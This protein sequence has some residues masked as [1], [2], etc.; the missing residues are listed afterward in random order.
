[1][2]QWNMDTEVE[3]RIRCGDGRT[4]QLVHLN[5]EGGQTGVLYFYHLCLRILQRLASTK[6]FGNRERIA[7]TVF[8]TLQE[9]VALTLTL[10]T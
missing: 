1:M 7:A 10:I 2:H 8:P 6:A 3:R 5:V 9:I 4:E